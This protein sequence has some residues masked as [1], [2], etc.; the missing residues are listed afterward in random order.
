M[1]A[2]PPI[3]FRDHGR[4]R[5]HR[6]VRLR[7]RH[8]RLRA[9]ARRAAGPAGR[10]RRLA[11]RDET[12]WN[13]RAILLEGRYKGETPLLVRQDGA[14][15][16]RRDLPQRGRG[17]QLDLLRRRDAAAADH[18]LRALADLLRRPRA[19]LRRSGGAARGARTRRRRSL[20]SAALERLP[21]PAADA[22][23]A[24]AADLRRGAAL[25][26]SPV[27]APHRHQPRGHARAPLPQLLHLRRVPVSDRRQE[28]HDP[29]RAQEGGSEPAHHPGAHAGRRACSSATVGSWAWK[30]SIARAGAGSRCARALTCCR[31]G[32]WGRR[33]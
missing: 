17:R 21:V 4:R 11:E 9:V 20:R 18:R 30:R 5:A 29:D 15:P 31:R 16:R 26:P 13:G 23:R 24:R 22:D 14:P 19:A 25:G 6:R 27:P 7:R 3:D 28:R 1:T 2:V 8:R 33:R 32:R 12:D 10:A